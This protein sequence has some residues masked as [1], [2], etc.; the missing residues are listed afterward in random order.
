MRKSIKFL[1]RNKTSLWQQEH[2]LPTGNHYANIKCLNG[3][4]TQSLAY[5]H[6]GVRNAWKVLATG[7]HE[8]FIWKAIINTTTTATTMGIHLKLVSKTSSL[9]SKPN[10]GHR[11]NS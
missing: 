5:G 9:Y 1:Y 11:K 3:F 10:T 4:A 8:S 7:W 2:S 6:I